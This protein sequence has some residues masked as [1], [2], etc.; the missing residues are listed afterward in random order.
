GCMSASQR[1][2]LQLGDRPFGADLR[3]LVIAEL[4]GNHNGQIERALALMEAAAK[5][6]AD[7]IKIQTYTAE[8]I[9][10]DY[11]GPG[12]T[13]E[14]GPWH[15]GRLHALYREAH[16]PWEWHETLFAKGRELDIPVFSTPFDFTAVGFLEKLGAPAYKIA[17]FECVDLPLIK[18][19]ASTG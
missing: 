5:A 7:A 11:D 9:T 10:L 4:S 2:R 14:G 3:P 18:R 1:A 16:T 6:G 17:S 8:T 12:F 19:C 15:G 13:I